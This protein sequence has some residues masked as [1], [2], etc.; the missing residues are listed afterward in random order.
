ME[1]DAAAAQPGR[2]L[3]SLESEAAVAADAVRDMGALSGLGPSEQYFMSV[4]FTHTYIPYVHFS[5]HATVIAKVGGTYLETDHFKL[6]KTDC[7]F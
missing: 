7:S 1:G 2:R 3:L 5:S 6:N 4:E